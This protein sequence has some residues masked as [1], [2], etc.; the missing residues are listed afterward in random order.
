MRCFGY[1][2]SGSDHPLRLCVQDRIS[3]ESLALRPV[4]AESE[5]SDFFL[6]LSSLVASPGAFGT[7]G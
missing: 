6:P 2:A 1:V 4:A 5:P 3:L 7:H